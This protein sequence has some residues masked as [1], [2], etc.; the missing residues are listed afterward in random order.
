[1]SLDLRC[2][3]TGFIRKFDPPQSKYGFYYS[4]Y[5]N[6]VRT[7]LLDN[8]CELTDHVQ[9]G[10]W[11]Q[12][13][14]VQLYSLPQAAYDGK[15][16]FC[17]IKSFVGSCEG[18]MSANR[19]VDTDDIADIRKE[20]ENNVRRAYLFKDEETARKTLDTLVKDRYS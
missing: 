5:D 2:K 17:I 20:I 19:N 13:E 1:M 18:C 14:Y 11:D 10:R 15:Y 9:D 4:K 7:G 12:T 3:L 8:G 16:K 6:Y